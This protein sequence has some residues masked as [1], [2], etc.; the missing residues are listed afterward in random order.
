M[1][2]AIG[3]CRLRNRSAARHIFGEADG[4]IQS[5]IS[6]NDQ[7]KKGHV[8]PFTVQRGLFDQDNYVSDFLAMSVLSHSVFRD[9][10]RFHVF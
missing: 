10:R 8:A 1:H 6:L 4:A 7:K 9:F 3:T 5:A 2:I